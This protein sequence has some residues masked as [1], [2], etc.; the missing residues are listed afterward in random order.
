M[1]NGTCQCE[2]KNYRTC[3]IDYIWNPTTCICE[4]GNYLKSIADVSKIVC[5]K[6]TYVMQ[7]TSTIVA[8]TIA[9]STVSINHHNKKVRY[10]MN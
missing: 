9:A 8:N 4:S 6:I 1:E 5:D 10:K 2:C 3:K 7:I